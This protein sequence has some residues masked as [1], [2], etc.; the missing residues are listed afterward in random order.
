MFIILIKIF[1]LFI[2]CIF[3]VLGKAVNIDIKIGNKVAQQQLGS[4]GRN[5]P[6]GV[7]HYT[8][9][10]VPGGGNVE[11][12]NSVDLPKGFIAE[13]NYI[14]VGHQ[15]QNVVSN[16]QQ[17][18]L[19]Q[20]TGNSGVVSKTVNIAVQNQRG[21]NFSSPRS[22]IGSESKGSSPRNTLVNPPPP[23]PYDHNR[24]SASPL[25]NLSPR[26]SLSPAES[27][28]SSPRTSI[29]NLNNLMYDRFPTPRQNVVST[30]HHIPVNHI[31]GHHSPQQHQMLLN[32]FHQHQQDSARFNDIGAPPPYDASKM[33]AMQMGNNPAAMQQQQHM[34]SQVRSHMLPPSSAA[35]M[36]RLQ[37]RYS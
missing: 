7:Q 25:S 34:T 28:H 17:Q 4:P 19:Y 21:S 23:P 11:V 2:K 15:N 9:K 12:V 32:R 16:Y 5:T 24:H 27:K 13:N 36:H 1:F 22:S 29:T 20:T 26:S 37:V 31:G 6:I 30:A 8:T 18:S 10:S 33:K 3:T 14:N 35:N